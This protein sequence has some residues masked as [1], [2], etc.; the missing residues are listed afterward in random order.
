[1]N[2]TL[3]TGAIVSLGVMLLGFLALSVDA[4]KQGTENTLK[5]AQVEANAQYAIATSEAK[6]VLASLLTR[7]TECEGDYDGTTDYRA[8]DCLL[9]VERVSL[10]A[11]PTAFAIWNALQDFVSTITAYPSGGLAVTSTTAHEWQISMEDCPDGEWLVSTG[12]AN[13][14]HGSYACA[15]PRNL[16]VV[17]R[18]L[19]ASDVAGL[20]TSGVT[21]LSAPPSGQY[22]I[23]RYAVFLKRNGPDQATLDALTAD[24]AGQS[25][26]IAIAIAPANVG[27]IT[28]NTNNP[29]CIYQA[30][31][32][33]GIFGWY[34][35]GDY[36]Y[37]VDLTSR[38]SSEWSGGCNTT[39]GQVQTMYGGEALT[40]A[41]FA[42]DDSG[43]S[44]TRTAE[45]VWDDF[46][47]NL[48]N[49]SL[50]VVV[51]YQVFDPTNP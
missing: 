31:L 40:I 23:P 5:A 2:K 51:Y 10:D 25:A 45:E 12:N 50:Q 24:I 9:W 18:T 37:A 26:G 43:S 28:G 35:H 15:A 44:P 33:N 4:Q 20:D 27:L 42:Q 3:I 34:A 16:L 6:S 46:T 41:G 11:V 7:E 13:A 30:W 29:D 47:A 48:N 14:P 38:T 21:L 19:S 49:L 36:Q 39:G 17:S 32:W 1:M 22:I 8:E